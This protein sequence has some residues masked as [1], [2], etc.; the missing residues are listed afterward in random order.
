MASAQ[1]NVHGEGEIVELG[2]GVTNR[3]IGDRRSCRRLA[4][5]VVR[6]RF[7]C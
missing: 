4:Y 3:A 2:S 5:H 6:E 7:F 1:G